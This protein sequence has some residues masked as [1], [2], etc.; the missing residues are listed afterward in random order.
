MGEDIVPADDDSPLSAA[1][2]RSLGLISAIGHKLIHNTVVV[3]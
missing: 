3:A 2:D 1:H